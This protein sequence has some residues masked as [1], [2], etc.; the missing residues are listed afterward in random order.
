MIDGWMDIELY[1]GIPGRVRLLLL[2]APDSCLLVMDFLY[3]SIC[4]QVLPYGF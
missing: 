3:S 4:G 2:Y 1:A